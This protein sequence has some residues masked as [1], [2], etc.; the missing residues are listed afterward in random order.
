MGIP[1]VG[2]AWELLSKRPLIVQRIKAKVNSPSRPVAIAGKPHRA[3]R[4][5]AQGDPLLSFRKRLQHRIETGL[6]DAAAQGLRVTSSLALAT[7]HR[8]VKPSCVMT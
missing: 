4:V 7:P 3:P 2:L 1:D 5:L 6:F 8:A